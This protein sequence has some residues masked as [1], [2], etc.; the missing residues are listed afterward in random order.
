VLGGSA[1]AP[2]AMQMAIRHPD[3]VSAL[4]LLVPLAWR[5]AMMADSSPPM[6]PWVESVLLRIIGSDFLFWVGQHLAREQMI[7]SVLATPPQRVAVA[8]AQERARVDAML[9][10]I[11][12]VSA[13]AEGLRSD[14]SLG[15]SLARY[16]LESLR[17]PTLIIS[18]RDDG[19]GTYPSAQYLAGQLAGSTFIGFNDGGHTWVGHDGEVQAAIL[20]LV[21]A[22]GSS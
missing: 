7:R 13:R 20:K 22:Q 18:A 21:T 10:R 6:T 2:S 9:A 12:P 8:S 4:I 11:L 1:G 3:R 19:Y 14:S 16:S 5:P 17:A 15:K